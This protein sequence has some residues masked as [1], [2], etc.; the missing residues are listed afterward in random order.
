MRAWL[1][2][3]PRFKMHF[4]PTSAS[5]LNLAER[6][7]SDPTGD[8]DDREVEDPRRVEQ[9]GRRVEQ[10]SPGQLRPP[11][12]ATAVEPEPMNGSMTR[13]PR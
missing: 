7:F 4:T 3:H 11:T 5:W 2:K 10:A 9:L 13:S 12:E 6:F 8:V 1:D